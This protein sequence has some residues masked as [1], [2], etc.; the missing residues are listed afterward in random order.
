[1]KKMLAVLIGAILV[2]S[3][4]LVFVSPVCA[5]FEESQKVITVPDD[6]QTIDEAIHAAERRNIIFVRNGTYDMPDNREVIINKPISIIGESV[7]NTTIVFHPN[8]TVVNPYS[9]KPTYR[10]SH[11]LTIFTDNFQLSGVNLQITQGGYINGFGDNIQLIGNS[12]SGCQNLTIRG[13][14]CQIIDNDIGSAV[15]LAVSFTEFS[16]NTFSGLFLYEG[17]TNDIHENT[18]SAVSIHCNFNNL[19]VGNKIIGSGYVGLTLGWSNNNFFYRNQIRGFDNGIKFVGTNSNV[20]VANS[21]SFVSRMHFYNSQNSIFYY[22]NF[23]NNF[24]PDGFTHPTIKDDH[25]KDSNIPISV[26]FWDNGTAGN[27]WHGTKIADNNGD[28]IGELPYEIDTNNIDNHP[29]TDTVKTDE[30]NVEI[31][32]WALNTTN[33]YPKLPVTPITMSS[34]PENHFNEAI[35][36][37]TSIIIATPL[38]T[39]TILTL[40]Y[41]KRKKQ[42]AYIP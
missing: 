40:F 12:F 30:I 10:Y 29:L 24:G 33:L 38:I 1:M 36:V 16:R 13:S 6:Y 41:N 18:C 3:G 17:H 39:G 7:Q 32:A 20:F 5:E 15:N 2:F 11:A 26:N 37:L 28:G 34:T 8:Y 19:I 42:K 4:F 25:F 14:Y 35:I 23:L 27:R 31:P 9:Y 22:N 21:I